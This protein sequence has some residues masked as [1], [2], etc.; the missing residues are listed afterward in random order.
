[1]HNGEDFKVIHIRRRNRGY[2]V[3]KQ[4]GTD[5]HRRF[6]IRC[7]RKNGRR[8]HNRGYRK[9]QTLPRQALDGQGVCFI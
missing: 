9:A 1:M 7:K 4:D 3:P 8:T 6:Q 5:C 2:T